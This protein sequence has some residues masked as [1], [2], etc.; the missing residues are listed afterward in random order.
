MYP[1]VEVE[2]VLVFIIFRYVGES[3]GATR[4]IVR[5]Y[6]TKVPMATALPQDE[7]LITEELL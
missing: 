7:A 6:S 3:I 2:R 1:N 5:R 4:N